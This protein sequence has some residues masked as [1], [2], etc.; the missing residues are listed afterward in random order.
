M[1]SILLDIN[2]DRCLEARIQVAFD[3]ARGFNGHV[4]CLRAIPIEFHVAADI[5]GSMASQVIPVTRQQVETLRKNVES[6]LAKEDVSWDWIDREGWSRH[7]IP[8]HALLNDIIVMGACDEVGDD[9]DYSVLAADVAVNSKTPVLLVPESCGA[10]DTG[11][12][13]VIA[14]NGS[15][16][17]CQ[18][19]RSALS[20]LQRASAVYLV[21]VKEDSKQHR[22]SDV[23]AAQY[24]A[25][26]DIKPEI[27]AIPPIKD[28]IAATLNNFAE[29]KGA[30]CIVM[31]AYGHSR[32]RE[33]VLGGVSRAMMKKPK[34]PL[35]LAH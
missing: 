20:L 17:A 29:S 9:G 10:F 24:L 23:A 1:R 19:I 33:F 30:S 32:F 4:T 5:Y 35:V 26:H 2:D 28:G 16:E 7:R 18:A 11:A 27:T 25:R 13:V 22:F 8:E 3:L 31:G 21:T 34:V 6:E 12:P 15:P 14:W